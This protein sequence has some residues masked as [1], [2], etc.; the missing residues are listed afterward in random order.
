MQRLPPRY[1]MVTSNTSEC[2]NSI[3]DKYRSEGWTGLLEGTLCKM[4]EKISENRQLYKTIQ[5]GDVV[6]KV[7]QTLKDRFHIAA[8]MQV[9]ELEVS[10]KYMFQ[11]LKHMVIH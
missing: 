8:A 6:T 9:V 1:G 10:Q 11:L 7:K 4:T 5:G 3:I 2:I